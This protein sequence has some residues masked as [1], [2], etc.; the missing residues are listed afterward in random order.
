MLGRAGARFPWES[1]RTGV[2]VTP[3]SARS[4]TGEIVPIRTGQLEEHIVADVAWAASCYMDWT[5]DEEFALGPARTLFVETA[6]YWASRV[7]LDRDGR[8]HIYGVIG[9]DEYHEPVDDNAFTNGMARW[10]LR[11]ALAATEEDG[12][13]EPE[14]RARWRE[15]ADLI[16][17]GFDPATGLYEQFAGFF[18]LEPLIVSEVA[19]RRPIVADLLLGRARTAD[20]QVVKQADVLMLHHMIPEGVA[21]AS[22]GPNLRFYEPR[23][24]HGSSLSPPVHAALFA[25]AGMLDEALELLHLTCRIDLADLTQT[26]AGGLHLATMGGLWQA[27]VHGF[28]G[29]RPV[30]E[31]LRLDPRVPAA[32]RRLEVALRFLGSRVK[33]AIVGD[34]LTVTADPPVAIALAGRPAPLAAGPTGVQLERCNDEWKQVAR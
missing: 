29:I 3:T 8:A 20:A 27:V 28:A 31:T 11:R 1:A 32:W 21:P 10:N 16:C 4:R 19:P 2:D 34:R 24:A 14:E 6:R 7:R 22:L 9:P 25:R 23:T 17:D 30:G 26:T 15:L 13:V 12:I 5:G 18:D 33:V